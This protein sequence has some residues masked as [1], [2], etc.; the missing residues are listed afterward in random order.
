ML[1]IRSLALIA[2]LALPL[3]AA[4]DSPAVI[5]ARQDLERLR[6]QVQAGLAPASKLVEAQASID[7]ALDAAILNRTLYGHLDIEKLSPWEADEMVNAA[8]RRV[9]RAQ[10][11]VDNATGLIAYGVAA[12]RFADDSKAELAHRQMAL[13]EAKSRAELLM[14]IVAIAR[15]ETAPAASENLTGI[16]KPREFVDGDHLLGP[17]EIRDITLSFENQFHEPLPVS[18]RG[19]TEVHRTL[20]FDHTGRIDVAVTPDSPEGQ[21]LRKFLESKNIPYYAFRV[22]IPGKATGAHI[23]IGPGSTRLRT[24]D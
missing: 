3:V 15:T 14:Q 7:D 4:D 19:M 10:K 24:T 2:L 12:P 23:H 8:T 6:E 5:Q 18:A 22:A 11:K 17:E 21:W 13:S 1:T 20:G 9:A 16:W